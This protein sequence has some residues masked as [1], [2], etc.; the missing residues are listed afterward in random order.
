[1]A[2][3]RLLHTRGQRKWGESEEKGGTEEGLGKFCVA[4]YLVLW[5]SYPG[6]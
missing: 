2:L 1:M 4:D 3:G 5:T 6:D